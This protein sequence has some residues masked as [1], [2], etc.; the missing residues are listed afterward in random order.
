MEDNAR[1]HG[2]WPIRLASPGRRI[3]WP[4]QRKA[5]PVSRPRRRPRFVL[6]ITLASGAEL[7]ERLL[8][9]GLSPDEVVFKYCWPRYA[10]P[11]ESRVRSFVNS[12]NLGLQFERLV[13][14]HQAVPSG[15]P[16]PVAAVWNRESEF[17]GYLL[18]YVGGET[19]ATLIGL[20]FFDEAL[21]Q[22]EAVE[23]TVVRLAAKSMPHGDLTPSNILAADDGRT[24]VIDPVANPGPG[25]HLQDELCLKQLRELIPS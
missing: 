4:R 12:E 18:E 23:K 20:G 17:V 10:P 7:D 8:E 2:G 24:L 5:R 15:V 11:A 6:D 1:R 22:V 14:M 19:L 3:P 16:M 25:T 21:R 13:E 9:Q